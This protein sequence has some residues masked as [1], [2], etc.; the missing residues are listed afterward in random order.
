MQYYV[1]WYSDDLVI[2]GWCDNWP[3]IDDVA[4]DN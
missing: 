3:L 2:G 4:V 1:A